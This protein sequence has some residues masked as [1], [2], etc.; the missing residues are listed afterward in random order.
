MNH[1]IIGAVM[2]L[3]FLFEDDF[4]LFNEYIKHLNGEKELSSQYK[5]KIN[6]RLRK[7]RKQ[8]CWTCGIIKDVDSFIKSTK[9]QSCK[10]KYHKSIYTYK[11]KTSGSKEDLQENTFRYKSVVDRYTSVNARA[12]KLSLPHNLTRLSVESM[13]N[14]FLDDNGV[15]CCAYCDIKLETSEDVH[16]EHIIPVSLLVKGS[17]EDNVVPSCPSCNAMKRDRTFTEWML[18]LERITGFVNYDKF[19]KLSTFLARYNINLRDEVSY[20][21]I[22]R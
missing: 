11:P 12:E 5:S 15:L 20:R 6:V 10:R 1:D 4:E 8:H 21:D 9:C 3:K 22:L 13:L 19:G 17:T 16:L 2:A 18:H 7:N 14:H